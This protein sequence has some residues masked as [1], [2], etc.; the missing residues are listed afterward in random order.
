MQYEVE[1]SHTSV[2][3][4]NLGTM[5]RSKTPGSAPMVGNSS[6]GDFVAHILWELK[7]G[8][9]PEDVCR[10]HGI[11]SQALGDWMREYGGLESSDIDRK[12]QME[13]DGSAKGRRRSERYG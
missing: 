10:A 12:L 3:A 7:A 5:P 11:S 6:L 9:S 2:L 1:G 4:A 8:K 13:E